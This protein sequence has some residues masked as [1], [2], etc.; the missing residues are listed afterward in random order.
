MKVPPLKKGTLAAVEVVPQLA[1]NGAVLAVVLVK[2][3][4]AVLPTMAVRAIAGAEIRLADVLWD[5]EHPERSSVRYPADVCLERP[6]T[7]VIVNGSA[8]APHEQTQPS[9]IASVRVAS[10]L[11]AV[12]V[13]GT[14]A[15]VHVLGEVRLGNP[16]PFRAVPIRWELAWGGSDFTDPRNPLEEPRNPVGKGIARDP[17]TLDGTPGPQIEAVDEPI[18]SATQRYTPAGFGALGRHWSPRR[19]RVGTVDESWMRER[20]PL[21]PADTDARMHQCAAP[22]LTSPEHLR[23][24]EEV[25]LVNLH[26][27]GPMRFTL[28]RPRYFVGM[29]LDGALSETPPVLDAV[30]IEPGER[31]FEMTWR[32]VLSMPARLSR[33][34]FIQVH[35]KTER[36]RS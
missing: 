13:T 26:P 10:L 35:E 9:L 2:Q 20:M 33:V 18:T 31:R 36:R 24:G 12:R 25:E 4:Y 17:R 15:W 8:V 6:G 22:A 28:P 32:S 27:A 21:W 7:D 29:K 34:E 23:G 16:T 19:E 3:R 1:M 30:L 11:S 14:R 5:P